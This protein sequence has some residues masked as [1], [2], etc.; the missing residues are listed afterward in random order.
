[1]RIKNWEFKKL[2][3]KAEVSAE[4]DG[5]RLW[6]RVPEAFSVSKTG[7]PFLAAALVP[8]KVQGNAIEIEQSLPVSPK[9]LKNAFKLQEIHHNWNPNFKKIQIKAATKPSRP[10]NDGAMSFFSGGV[11][12]NYT[13][14]THRQEISHNVY[15]MGFDFFSNSQRT[16]RITL[17]DISDLAQLA[18]KLMLEEDKIYRFLKSM[19]SASTVNALS[20]YTDSFREPHEVEAALILE[21][22][23]I[24]DGISIYEEERF[25]GIKL[26]KKTTEFLGRELQGNELRN[27]NKMLLEDAY[28]HE[29][30]G[31]ADEPYKTAVQRIERYVDSFGKTLIPVETNHSPFGYRYNLSRNLSQGGALGSVA[32]LLGFPRVYVPSSSTHR[33]VFPIGTHPLT[34]HLYAHEGMEIIHDGCDAGRAEK[35]IEICNYESAVKN[36]RVCFADMNYNCGKCDKCM[37]TMI[38]MKFLN[39]SDLVFPAFPPLKKI[40]RMDLDGLHLTDLRETLD[41]VRQFEQK[42]L[43]KTLIACVKRNERNRLFKDFDK[44]IMGGLIKK[45]AGRLKKGSLGIRRIDTMPPEN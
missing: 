18:H 40:R 3:D 33:H 9:I 23:K 31:N 7:D 14:L 44:V 10:L 36:L 12:S 4:I 32:L 15:M 35:T 20:N 28:P 38:T 22:N 37:R 25:A 42:E 11:D 21:L 8:A 30:A 5:F 13:L 45:L 39:K 24:I 34:D 16:T 1:M 6:Y 17:G 26:R 41:Y 27:L 2:N 19:F 43:Y 29:L